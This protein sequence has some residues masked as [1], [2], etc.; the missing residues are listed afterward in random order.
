MET[1]NMLRK[2]AVGWLFL[3]LLGLAAATATSIGH[4][5]FGVPIHEAHSGGR[6]ATPMEVME[7]LLVLASVS[8][9]FTVMGAC[10]LFL[11]RNKD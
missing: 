7:N 10:I 6:L 5:L 2:I 8:G 1:S 11:R 9:L 3:G 4:Y